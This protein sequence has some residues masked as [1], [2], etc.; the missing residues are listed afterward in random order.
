MHTIYAELGTFGTA[1]VFELAD[2][3]HGFRFVP[4]CAGQYVLDTDAAGGWTRSST[5]CT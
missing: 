4:L 2:L 5:A 3:R 1:F